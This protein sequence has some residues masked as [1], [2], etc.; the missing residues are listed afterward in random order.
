MITAHRE[1]FKSNQR[2]ACYSVLVHKGND[3]DVKKKTEW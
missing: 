2:A 1:S 3:D